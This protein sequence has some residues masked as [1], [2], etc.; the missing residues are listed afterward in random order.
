MNGIMGYKTTT[1]PFILR[2]TTSMQ[3]TGSTASTHTEVDTSLDTLNREVLLIWEVDIQHGDLPRDAMN[4]LLDGAALNQ[5]VIRDQVQTETGL[6]NLDDQE[7]IAGKDIQFSG[8]QGTGATNA[9]VGFLFDQK[10]PDST[11]F[12]SKDKNPLAIVTSSN[13]ILR[14]DFASSIAFSTSETYQAFFR[15]HAQRAKADADTYAAL[16]TGLL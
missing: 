16:V 11:E 14:S 10:N 12:P 4:S 15:I 13:L 6:F 7:Y 5:F 2:G 9:G 1:D 3:I 8:R